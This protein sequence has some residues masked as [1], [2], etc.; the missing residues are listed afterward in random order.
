M[1][2]LRAI[3]AILG[4]YGIAGMVIFLMCAGFYWGAVKPTQREL[5]AQQ[6]ASRRLKS[7]SAVQPVSIDNRSDDLRRF[8]T[9]FP[10]TAK[11]APEMQKLWVVANEYKIDLQQGEYRLES[12]GAGLARYRITLP[13]RASYG[14]IRQ[15]VGFVLKEIPTMSIDGLRFERKKISDTQLDAQ[16]KLTL[17]LQPAAVSAASSRAP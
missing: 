1:K 17:Y 11:I 7:R 5:S 13:V 10:T 14:Q 8:Y 15:F 12:S 4:P 3:A 16:I 9:L 6:E 2:F